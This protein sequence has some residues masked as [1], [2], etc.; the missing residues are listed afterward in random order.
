MR[1]LWGMNR[2]AYTS[3]L[4][5]EEWKVLQPLLPAAKPGGR[6]RT[7]NQRAVGNAIFYLVSSSCAWHL[8]PYEFP[9]WQT[10]Y[11]YWRPWRTAEV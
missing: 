2:K 3:D 11:W 10:V 7:A 8:L 4:S 5:E 1:E 6:P 9:P